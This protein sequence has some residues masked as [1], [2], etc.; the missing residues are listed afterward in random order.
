[1]VALRATTIDPRIHTVA[2]YKY[3]CLP[4][5]VIS[6]ALY[7]RLTHTPWQETVEM[8]VGRREVIQGHQ[9][10]SLTT[11]ILAFT[12]ES[13]LRDWLANNDLPKQW[14]AY[15]Y[16]KETLLFLVMVL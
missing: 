13:T 8:I 11:N 9:T 4:K 16:N 7:R 3:D 6:E 12:L 15:E 10:P 14:C 2:G 5:G 1:M